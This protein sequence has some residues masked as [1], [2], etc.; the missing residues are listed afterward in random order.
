[1]VRAVLTVHQVP[2]A[3]CVLTHLMLTTLHTLGAVNYLAHFA[4]G[5]Q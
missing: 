1:M 4:D 3:L 5:E 2:R